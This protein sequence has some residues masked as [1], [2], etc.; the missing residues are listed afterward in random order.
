MKNHAEAVLALGVSRARIAQVMGLL[1]LSPEFQAAGAG[2][3]GDERAG[4][5]GGGAGGGLGGPAQT[6]R[7]GSE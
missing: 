7:I 1:H 5:E 4:G 3:G 6:P 2:G